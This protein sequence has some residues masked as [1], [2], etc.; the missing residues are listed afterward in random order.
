[1]SERKMDG[2]EKTK[3]YLLPWGT[4][5][6]IQRVLNG[7]RLWARVLLCFVALFIVLAEV[8]EAQNR[9][10]VRGYFRRD[11][12][13]VQP[14]YRTAPD[15]NPYNNYSFPGNYNPN[16][17]RITPGDPLNYLEQYYR[18][19]GGLDIT[20]SVRAWTTADGDLSALPWLPDEVVSE[21]FDRSRQHCALVYPSASTDMSACE[22]RQL[23]ALYVT[24][25]PDYSDL[26]LQEVGRSARHCEFVYGDDRAG[27]YN[28]LNRQVFGLDQ[29]GA[30]FE[31]SDAEDEQ[32][33]RAYCEFVYG[34][35]RA[36]AAACL[37]RQ[38]R[39]LGGEP[40]SGEGIPSAEWQRA[41][42][43]CEFL[44]GDNRAGFTACLERQQRGM[45]RG[46]PSLVA[47]PSAE[48]QR[49]GQY[50]ELLYGDNRA[51]AWACLVRQRDGISRYVR[52]GA[53]QLSPSA[54]SRSYC[55]R[56]YGDNRAGYW[57]C[58]ARR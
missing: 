43:Y 26:L 30:D 47:I 4:I 53:M 27:F 51:G 19:R 52:N 31:T 29:L 24:A 36:G 8:A 10:R 56:L 5:N 55:E 1:M 44:Y 48:A 35:N 16:T 58:V 18:D 38:A 42:R 21:E 57:S 39:G 20:T 22:E 40:P 12:T 3:S 13:Y 45:L 28:C 7:R 9:V 6:S 46:A 23:R 14:H 37:Q 33:A 15:G 25:L 49:A 11:G 54:S 50:C 34:D 41:T 2:S 17:G 32:R